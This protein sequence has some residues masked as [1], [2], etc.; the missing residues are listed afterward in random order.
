M[1]S[2][3]FYTDTFKIGGFTPKSLFAKSM[4][5]LLDS[6]GWRG[7][8]TDLIEALVEDANTMDQ[9]DLLKVM[10]NLRFEGKIHKKYKQIQ[11]PCLLV[12]KDNVFTVVNRI[13]NEYQVYDAAEGT[14]T[15][16]KD[17]HFHGKMVTFKSMNQYRFSLLKSQ[18]NWF[19]QLIQRFF[20]EFVYSGVLTL[21]MSILSFITPLFVMLMYSQMQTS[22]D[23]MILI[24]LGII[25][26]LFIL[27]VNGLKYFRASLLSHISE[28]MGNLISNEVYRRLYYLS[29]QFTEVAS[30]RQQINRVK[31]FETI[32][33]F[34][35]D[36]VLSSLLDIPM[37]VL[38]LAGLSVIAG[39]VVL[40]PLL[41][42][43]IYAILAYFS[44]K[45]YRSISARS[46]ESSTKKSQIQNEMIRDL[47]LIR[48]SGKSSVW[49]DRAAKRAAESLEHSRQAKKVLRKVN[50][51]AK[52][53]AS[54]TLVSSIAFCAIQVLS[55]HMSGGALFASFL[56]ISR[57]LG[58][59]TSGVSVVS[60]LSKFTKS[61]KQLNN[62]MTMSIEQRPHTLVR[63]Y[64]QLGGDIVFKNIFLKYGKDMTPVLLNVSFK[65]QSRESLAITGHGASG[66]SSVFKLLLGMYSPLSGS[67]L[68]DNQNLKQQDIIRLRKSIAYIPSKP[69]VFSGT[70]LSNLYLC[71]PDI[72]DEQLMI[73]LEK[74]GLSEIIEKL[75]D[76]IMTNLKDLPAEY[77][78]DWFFKYINIAQALSKDAPIYLIDEL[79]RG[80]TETQVESLIPLINDLKRHS[81]VLLISNNQRLVSQADKWISL[82]RG[83]IVK[84][85]RAKE[86]T[87]AYGV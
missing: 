82:D 54:I 46:I 23:P 36:R 39:P 74:L 72:Q 75:P 67:I 69:Y 87:G 29:P 22:K 1:M 16:I 47:S 5:P 48:Q 59:F 85:G 63:L 55:G 15:G 83:R 50:V 12:C 45:N 58:P 42:F 76:G 11:F 78:Q 9:E 79:D 44:Y 66:R 17:I 43:L 31:D 24:Y 18:K 20:K 25:V 30:V 73:I 65:M 81:T 86:Y 60:Q 41:S 7:S 35:S 52:S 77:R 61:V 32:K 38:M 21:M 84:E 49:F 80:L 4:I 27:S 64:K 68:I 62:L 70:L 3:S 2:S 26:L 71:R 37:S 34:F 33:S 57:I 28:R 8:N 10:A 51:M 6:L 40:I 13:G 14:Y 56:I 19:Q 53:L